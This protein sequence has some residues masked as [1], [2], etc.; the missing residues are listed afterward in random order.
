MALT[1]GHLMRFQRMTIGP[2]GLGPDIRMAV[3]T[4]VGLAIAPSHEVV[5]VDF[6]TT[7]AYHS[8][9]FMGAALPM[10]AIHGLM[11]LQ[12]PFIE[13]DRRIASGL[14]GCDGGGIAFIKSVIGAGTM[15]GFTSLL[16]QGNLAAVEPSMNFPCGTREFVLMTLCTDLV[17]NVFRSAYGKNTDK[18]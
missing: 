9:A 18:T 17:A 13:R 5:L 3:V 6:M 1:A 11:A 15:T 4:D 7:R 2:E 12:T 10:P 8:R 16:R 14:Q